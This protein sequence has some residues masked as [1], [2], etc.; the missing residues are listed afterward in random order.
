MNG[1]KIR[2]G[3]SYISATFL[4]FVVLLNS[5]D[6][7]VSRSTNPTKVQKYALYIVSG[8]IPSRHRPE[9]LTK[10]HK[11]RKHNRAFITVLSQ[12]SEMKNVIG[13]L[14]TLY[15]VTRNAMSVQKIPG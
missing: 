6:E 14:A 11:R 3:Y 10:D 7:P 4:R 12:S 1:L 8:L 9:N 2:Y 13:R 15:M 5:C